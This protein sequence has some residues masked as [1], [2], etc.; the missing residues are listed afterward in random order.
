MAVTATGPLAFT[1][2]HTL[3]LELGAR[4]VPFAGYE[5][6]IQYDG[7]VAEL[8]VIGV[9]GDLVAFFALVVGGGLDLAGRD[10]GALVGV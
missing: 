8:V 9:V 1:P 7:I 6:P 2:L 4:M 5:M 3:H 10:T